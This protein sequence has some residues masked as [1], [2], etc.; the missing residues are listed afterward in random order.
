MTTDLQDHMG[1]NLRLVSNGQIF[2][3]PFLPTG[4]KTANYTAAVWDLVPVNVSAANV[5]IA[6]PQFHTAGDQIGIKLVGSTEGHTCTVDGYGAQTI[7]GAAT[8]VMFTDYEWCLLIS[9]GT[10]WLQIG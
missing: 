7:D 5:T 2:A 6:L 10:S 9:T 4:T 1:R 3:V 8:L